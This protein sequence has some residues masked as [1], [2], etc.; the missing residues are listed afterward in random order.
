MA[1]ATACF[2]LAS[3]LIGP[4]TLVEIAGTST[5]PS[6]DLA[7]INSLGITWYV[8]LVL[9]SL[10]VCHSPSASSTS[11]V[12]TYSPKLHREY[13]RTRPKS[14]QLFSRDR[15]ITAGS[16]PCVSE[17]RHK[18]ARTRLPVSGPRLTHLTALH[19]RSAMSRM[20]NNRSLSNLQHWNTQQ[21]PKTMRTMLLVLVLICLQCLRA[22]RPQIKSSNVHSMAHELA[23]ICPGLQRP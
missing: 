10:S 22:N 14:E 16:L 13:S 7:D 23:A 18:R 5:T 12:Y 8:E 2:T 17:D 4:I 20:A 11:S 3:W 9:D 15:T 19:S 6:L 21:F 1:S